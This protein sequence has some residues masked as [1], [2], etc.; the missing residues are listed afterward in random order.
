M[1]FV[2]QVLCPELFLSF[3]LLILGNACP[4]V[5]LCCVQRRMEEV[6]VGFGYFPQVTQL[7]DSPHPLLPEGHVGGAGLGE[8]GRGQWLSYLS[9]WAALL[10]VKSQYAPCRTGAQWDLWVLHLV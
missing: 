6:A 1:L 5:R 10:S 9:A 8:W 2:L 7:P 4:T 3:A